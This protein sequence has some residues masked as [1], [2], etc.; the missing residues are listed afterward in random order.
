M[1]ERTI[2]KLGDP[3]LREVC[4]PVTE[5]T[6]NIIKLLDDMA[7]TLYAAPG[8]AGLSAPQVGIAKRIAVMDCGDG[9]IELINPEIMRMS[10][11]QVGPEA[12]LSIPG[13]IGTV[14]RA[15]FVTVKTLTRTGDEMVMECKGFL[16]RCMQHE[17]DHLNGVLYIDHVKQGHLYHELTKERVDVL[18]MIRISRRNG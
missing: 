11:K 12:C 6:P 2:R 13:F 15:D 8:R 10:G 14:K 7:E 9:L 1:A 3:A 17:I 4:K 5:I 18:E 16:A